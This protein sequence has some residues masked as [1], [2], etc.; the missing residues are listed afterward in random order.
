MMAF[1]GLT[2]DMVAAMGSGHKVL[3]LGVTYREE[4]SKTGRQGWHCTENP[5]DCLKYFSLGAGNRHFR[6]E[7]G[8]SIDEDEQERISCTEITL[9]EELTLRKLAGYGMLYM[10]K[11]P[12]RQGWQQAGYRIRVQEDTAEAAGPDCIAIARGPRP[13]VRGPEGAVLGLILEP[14]PGCITAAKLFTADRQQAGGWWTV[15]ENRNLIEVDHEK[16]F[17]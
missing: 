4:S 1:K 12:L 16:E 7:A 11:H 2:A 10:V 5:F 13:Q 17:G 8:G 3:E 6:V 14:E 15:D 9:V